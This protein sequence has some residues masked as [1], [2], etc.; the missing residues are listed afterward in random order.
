MQNYADAWGSNNFARYFLNS[1]LVAVAT[2]VLTV[3]LASMMA[4]GFARFDFPGRRIL[5]AVVVVGLTVPT[6][7]LII[8]QFLLARDLHLLDSLHGLVRSTSA[9]NWP[10]ARSSCGRSSNGCRWS[11]TRRW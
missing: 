9:R 1:T 6:M 11:W 8:P 10:S 3:L 2:T 5:F 4:Y 7:L